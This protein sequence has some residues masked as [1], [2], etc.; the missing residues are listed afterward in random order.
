METIKKACGYTLSIEPDECYESPR[1]WDNMAKMICFHKRD[2]LGDKHDY[3]HC[4]YLG[5]DGMEAALVKKEKPIVI[6]R[7]YMMDHSGL[8][9]STDSSRFR[10]CDSNGWDWGTLGFVL[11]PR[12]H[13]ELKGLR[14]DKAMERANHTVDTE[15]EVYNQYLSGD[16]WCWVIKDPDGA[17][18]ESCGGCYGC[19]YAEEEA[20]REFDEFMAREGAKQCDLVA[21]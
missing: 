17:V 10:A 8:T 7:L 18:V 1:E 5:W 20:V 13:P 4:D 2:A 21:V 19:K 3:K 12:G 14:K 11:V 15:V 9:I 6:R 16:V